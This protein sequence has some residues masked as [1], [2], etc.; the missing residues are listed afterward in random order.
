MESEGKENSETSGMNQDNVQS[1]GNGG[2]L[3]PPVA[4]VDVADAE[5]EDADLFPNESLDLKPMNT[6]EFIQRMSTI[7]DSV[8]RLV[9]TVTDLLTTPKT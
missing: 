6:M 2:G 3:K 8:K 1:S 7:R 4:H 5:P 9:S